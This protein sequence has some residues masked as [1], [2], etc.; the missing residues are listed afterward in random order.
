MTRLLL[1]IANAQNRRLLEEALAGHYP[2]IAFDE[3]RY[4]GMLPSCDLIVVDGVLLERYSEA[5]LDAKQNALP[6]LLPVLLVT[7][8]RNVGLATRN[9]WKSVDEVI[10]SPIEPV[11][12]QARVVVMLRARQLSVELYQRNQ[13]MEAFV[14]A[15]AHELRAP[16]RAM[17]GFATALIEDAEVAPDTVAADY[18]Q[19]IVKA[20]EQMKQILDVLLTLARVGREVQIQTVW[21]KPLLDDCLQDIQSPNAN[22]MAYID[23]DL[24]CDTVEADP[25]LLKIVMT[26]LISN[27][28]KFRSKDREPR[29]CIASRTRGEVCRIEVHDNGIGMAPEDVERVFMPFT[30]LHGV[31]D[32]PGFGLGLS[33]VRKAVTAMNGRCGAVSRAGEGSTFWIELPLVE[34]DR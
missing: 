8:R 22:I 34:G 14:H 3:A 9:L 11:E 5:I 26:N 6:T 23:L 4:R 30:R 25:L 7:S 19:R 29:V 10:L 31:E 2:V 18:L 13:D 1:M 20:S 15:V 16:L 21:L 24:Q 32:Y 17:A 33:I 28:L 27:A 12:L